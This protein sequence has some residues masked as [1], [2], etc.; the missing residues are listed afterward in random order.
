MRPLTSLALVLLSALAVEAIDTSFFIGRTQRHE[1]SDRQAQRR[2]SPR[3]KRDAAGS[4][5][6]NANTTKFAVNGTGIP[7]VNFDAGESYAGQLPVND[8]GNGSLF[9]WFWPTTNTDRPKEILLW[10]NGG[11]GCS[12]L[13][14]LLQENGPVLWSPGT[15]KPVQ[16]PWSWHHITNV[17]WVEQPIGT[18]FSTGKVTAKNEDDVA[19][20]FM[21]FWKNFIDTF[22]MQ[23]YKVYITGESYAGVYC[24]YI[25]S[26]FLDAKD[27]T[28]FD[29]RGMMINDPVIGDFTASMEI[30]AHYH[31]EY[32][33]NS[34]PLNESTWEA[35]RN[36][37]ADCGYDD[38]LNK[39]LSFPPVGVQPTLTPGRSID[40]TRRCRVS[41]LIENAIL[42][43]NPGWNIYQVTQLLPLP[44]DVLG[45]PSTVE[46]LPKGEQIYFD[47]QDVKTAIHAPNITWSVCNDPVFVDGDDDSDVPILSVLPSVID[48][49]KNVMITHGMND[50][51]LI[52]NGTLLN[53]Q[54]MT[55]GGQL[56]FQAR[57]SDPLFIPHHNDDPNVDLAT[58]SGQ[59]V[60]GTTHTE[61]GLTWVL[62]MLTGHMVPT[63]QASVSYR[64]IEVL[65]GRVSSLNSTQAFSMYSS[66]TQPSAD[67]LGP[68]SAPILGRLST[69][70]FTANTTNKQNSAPSR[71]PPLGAW[72][73][74]GLT[75]ALMA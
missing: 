19:K 7:D 20:Q 64:Q 72:L 55:W 26:N 15:F 46:F 21:G 37:S 9:F 8:G 32:W 31:T 67:S 66:Q 58:I 36:A 35:V 48:R 23:G 50:F 56:G 10:L 27:T 40:G 6:N 22:S 24:P 49:T 42:D 4:P 44:A 17:V 54:N 43:I 2:S 68:G 74:G 3:L 25:A 11:P 60:M 30:P 51:V 70:P 38:F 65:L 63:W 41:D 33:A 62:V 16:N 69:E 61:R 59:G 5:F 13:A 45:F 12:S 71:S 34:F 57:P 28:Y 18:G 73:L 29:V 75:L 1:F 47:R 52:P 14:G 39:Y 53:I